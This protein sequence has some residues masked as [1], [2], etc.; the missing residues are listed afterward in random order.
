[1]MCSGGCFPPLQLGSTKLYDTFYLIP[2]VRG[3]ELSSTQSIQDMESTIRCIL[4]TIVT[5]ICT[6]SRFTCYQSILRSMYQQTNVTTS[7]DTS[8]D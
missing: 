1:M 3:T 2:A 4:Q 8:R 5:Y 6:C 7:D